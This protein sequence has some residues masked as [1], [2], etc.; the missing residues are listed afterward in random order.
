MIAT[1]ETT[2]VREFMIRA[3]DHV[4]ATLVFKGSG[5]NEVGIIDSVR[6]VVEG[7]SALKPGDEVVAIDPR[8]FR[9]SEVDLVIGRSNESRESSWD[10]NPN[11]M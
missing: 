2:S 3:F 8:Y 11:M 5:V 4:G 6:D 7:G 1:G 10:G 9:P